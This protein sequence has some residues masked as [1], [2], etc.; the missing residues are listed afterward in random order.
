MTR[1]KLQPRSPPPSWPPCPASRTS[2]TKDFGVSNGGLKDI[3]QD[4]IDGLLI[5]CNAHFCFSNDFAG[6][7]VKGSS[8]SSI[9]AR[10]IY[11][12]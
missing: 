8:D 5:F 4:G 10:F 3:Y 12:I 7:E 11:I 9:L 2:S 6:K 1:R